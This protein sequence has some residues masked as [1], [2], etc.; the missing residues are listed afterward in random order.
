MLGEDLYERGVA[1]MGN[2]LGEDWIKANRK[3]HEAAVAAG[4]ADRTDFST[5]I[6]F[7]FMMQRPQLSLRDRALV[8]VTSDIVQNAPSALRS[9]LQIALHAGVTRDEIREVVFMMT[10]YCGFP[11]ARE[12]DNVISAYFAEL[13]KAQP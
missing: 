1:F 6:L 13:D 9:H 12:A 11:K 5:M 3:R 7:G 4:D 8:M 2:I 10:Q